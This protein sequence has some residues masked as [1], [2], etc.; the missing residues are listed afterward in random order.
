M[1]GALMLFIEGNLLEELNCYKHMDQE[2]E[3][4]IIK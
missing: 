1:G 3:I 4:I 2:F